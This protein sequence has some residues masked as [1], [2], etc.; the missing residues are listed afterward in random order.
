MLILYDGEQKEQREKLFAEEYS[1]RKKVLIISNKLNWDH[2][3]DQLQ[4]TFL[5][6]SG[7]VFVY[8]LSGCGFESRCNYLN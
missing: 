2:F 4:I 7:C 3:R 8:E 6:S 1:T 5:T